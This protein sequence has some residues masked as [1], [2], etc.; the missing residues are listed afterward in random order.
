MMAELNF[1]MMSHDPSEIRLICWFGIQKHL[2][3][4]SM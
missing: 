1:Q 3:L 2:L 4:L